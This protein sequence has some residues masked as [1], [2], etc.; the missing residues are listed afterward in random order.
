MMS[1]TTCSTSRP[2]SSPR[3]RMAANL[4]IEIGIVYIEGISWDQSFAY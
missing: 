3:A 1:I 4:H 2:V